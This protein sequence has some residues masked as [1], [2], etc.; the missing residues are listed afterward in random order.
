MSD[1]RLITINAP[2]FNA[3]VVVREGLVVDSAPILRYMR[4]WHESRVFGYAGRKGWD[5]FDH[6]NLR[7]KT[8][9]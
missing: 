4:G 3:A 6:A 2:H 7:P 8:T 5:T 1:E 9:C